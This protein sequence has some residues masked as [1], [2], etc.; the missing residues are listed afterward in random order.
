MGTAQSSV[1]GGLI[2]CPGAAG[3]GP[4]TAHSDKGKL[5]RLYTIADWRA[6]TFRADRIM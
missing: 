2:P 6:L 1:A 3:A 4:H 5:G